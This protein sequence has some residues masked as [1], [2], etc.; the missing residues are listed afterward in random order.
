MAKY[1]T[2]FDVYL[3]PTFQ[4]KVAV[5]MCARRWSN[6]VSEWMYARDWI[7]GCDHWN[8]TTQTPSGSLLEPTQLA[9]RVYLGY[10]YANKIS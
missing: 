7:K 8:S 4:N 10:E 3:A 9:L 2:D 6:K 5:V 1:N